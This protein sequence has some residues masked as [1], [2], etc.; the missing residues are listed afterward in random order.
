MSQTGSFGTTRPLIPPGTQLNGIYEIDEPIAAGGMGEIYKGH[1]IQ[2]GDEVAI[3]LIR[4]DVAEAEAAFALFRKEA[5]ALH[6]LY[7]EAIVR[8]YVFTVDP[9]L[10]RPYLAMEYVDGQSLSEI[11]RGGPLAFEAVYRLMQ[12]IAAGLHAAHERGIVHRDVSPDNIIIPAGEMGRAKIIDF[13]IAKS[14]RLGDDGTVIGSGFAGKYNYVS[15]EQLG[16]YGGNVTPRSDI[17]SLGLVLAEALRHGPIDM[18][19]SHVDVIDKRRSVP[20]VGPIDSRLR[21]LIEKMLQPNPEDRPESMAEVANW[22]VGSSTT[23]RHARL[24]TKVQQTDALKRSRDAEQGSKKTLFI[25]GGV[26]ATL[27]A[28]AVGAFTLIHSSPVPSN[29]TEAPKLQANDSPTLTNSESQVLPGEPDG[30]TVKPGLAPMDIGKLATGQ[31]QTILAANDGRPEKIDAVKRYLDKYDGG[32]CFYVKPIQI[33]DSSAALEGYGLSEAPFRELDDAFRKSQGF[34]ADIGVRQVSANQ[35]SAVKFLNKLRGNATVAPYIDANTA[36]LKAGQTLSGS[37]NQLDGRKT[38][39]VLVASDG[40]VRKLATN[41]TPN[42][43]TFSLPLSPDIAD[44]KV[45]MLVAVAGQQPVEALKS[46]KLADA[47]KLFPQILAD[48]K[49]D[50]RLTAA[51]KLFKAER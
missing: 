9:I 3:K 14:T 35:C 32:D 23:V 49:S 24:R 29:Q 43:L 47:D 50:P 41:P 17:Y 15:P 36:N 11:L 7:H 28:A 40:S 33:A 5:S 19:G 30:S 42:G 22:A 39:L 6:N 44:G 37:L 27:A 2:T 16:L 48:E 20:D 1:A 8:Y 10:N 34:E 46:S 31:P 38:D 18:G 26:I 12:R 51:V 13:G 21:P 4:A 25:V 45:Q